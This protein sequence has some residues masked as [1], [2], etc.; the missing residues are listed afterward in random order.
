MCAS[1]GGKH[2]YISQPLGKHVVPY[3]DNV[4][5]VAVIIIRPIP[6]RH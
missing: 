5:L 1:E 2:N 3:S 6:V 4:G